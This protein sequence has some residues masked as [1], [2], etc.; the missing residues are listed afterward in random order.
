M[1]AEG[2]KSAFSARLAAAIDPGVRI[3]LFGG[4]Q[5]GRCRTARPLTP[6]RMG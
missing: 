2:L 6:Q 1:A 5:V 4:F 3:R